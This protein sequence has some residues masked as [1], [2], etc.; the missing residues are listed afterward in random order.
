MSVTSLVDYKNLETVAALRV[1]LDQAIA[2]EL[3]GIAVCVHM[4]DGNERS[5]FTGPYRTSAAGINATMRLC[6]QLTQLQPPLKNS[7]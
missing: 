7:G 1:L 4:R 5:C 6:W 2:G 3:T